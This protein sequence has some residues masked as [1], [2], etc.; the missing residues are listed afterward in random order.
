MKWSLSKPPYDVQK[1]GR[2]RAEGKRGYLWL[3]DMGLGKT[4]VCLDEFVE[5][6]DAGIVDCL[7]V[8]CLNYF[9][10]AWVNEATNMGIVVTSLEWPHQHR[11][12]TKQIA[13]ADMVVINWES[14][15]HSGGEWLDHNFLTKR[16]VYLAIDESQIIKNHGSR[17]TKWFMGHWKDAII[18]R[19]LT[20]TPMSQ[21]V[22]DLF[23]QLRLAH[24]LDGV[25]PYVFR[26][27]YAKLGGYM[28]KQVVGV[29]E[30]RQAEL[31]EI[32]D[33][34]SFRA[35]KQDWLDLPE[36]MYVPAIRVEMP[37]SLSK[38]YKPMEEEFVAT[39]DSGD[40]VVAEMVISQLIK[41][42]EIS[43]GFI[44][45]TKGRHIPLAEPKEIPKYKVALSL[46][47]GVVGRSK[48]LI[49]THFQYTS[50]A[51][52]DLIESNF[53]FRPAYLI[54][55]MQ[56]AEIE[57]QKSAFNSDAG[58]PVLVAQLSV[59]NA[60]HTLLGGPT[61][62]CH[63]VLYF[64][65]NYRLLHRKQSED[66]IHR[67]GQRF[68]CSYYDIASS[69]I[70]AAVIKNLQAKND[71]VRAVVDYASYTKTKSESGW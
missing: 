69:R 55:G 46:I 26:N 58:P 68:A 67:I 37:A 45:D 62:P 18:R 70:E 16:R 51:L 13:A 50:R 39:L 8:V 20:G 12:T 53:A 30:D 65:N 25:N 27:R 31:N 61:R 35:L 29:N 42:Q 34:H 19:G 49:F 28:G 15:I 60:S 57:Q 36:K 47:D 71:V 63:S 54:G 17:V 43:S 66:R 59:G 11:A 4:G 48:I 5:L 23:P 44:I 21:S 6:R 3:M 1:E 10:R 32:L 38:H 9:Q 64:E 24:A 14:I 52:I 33:L 40:E 41:L 22:M 2:R 56:P 7:V